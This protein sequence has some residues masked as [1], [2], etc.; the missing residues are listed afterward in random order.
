MFGRFFVQVNVTAGLR[1]RVEPNLAECFD[2][3]SS[4]NNRATWQQDRPCIRNW[5]LLV[6][7][8]WKA[9]IGK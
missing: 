2:D 3:I 9:L 4:A 8:D 6:E 7:Q 5:R 1:N